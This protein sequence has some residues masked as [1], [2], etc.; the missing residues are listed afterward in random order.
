MLDRIELVRVNR[1]VLADAA[2]LEP[3]TLR[4]L[5]AIHLATAALFADTLGGLITYDSR[6]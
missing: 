1:Q 5:D 3:V 4:S 6:G 2:L